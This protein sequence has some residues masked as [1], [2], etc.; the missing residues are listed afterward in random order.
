MRPAASSRHPWGL[1]S[2]HLLH[3]FVEVF[4]NGSFGDKILPAN[5]TRRLIKLRV[6]LSLTPASVGGNLQEQF[7][8]CHMDRKGDCKSD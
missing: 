7:K 1:S 3:G 4:A 2:T 5:E 8:P 6:G